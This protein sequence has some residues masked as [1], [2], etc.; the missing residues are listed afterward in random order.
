VKEWEHVSSIH[1]S[2]TA[3]DPLVDGAPSAQLLRSRARL[4]TRKFGGCVRVKAGPLQ[5]LEGILVRKK[6]PRDL[7]FPATASCLRLPLKLV[8]RRLAPNRA[9]ALLACS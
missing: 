8:A 5:S 1:T 3:R 2:S 9:P 6:T 7:L 4:R